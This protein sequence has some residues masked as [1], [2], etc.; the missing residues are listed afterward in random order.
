[1]TTLPFSNAILASLSSDLLNKVSTGLVR[2]RLVAGQS[3]C[4]ARYPVSTI[5][6]MEHG[7]ASVISADDS[8]GAGVEIALVGREGFVSPT[9]AL[10]P[11]AKSFNSIVAR[12]DGVAYKMEFGVFWRLLKDEPNFR[13]GIFKA[14]EVFCAEVQ[15]ISACNM[16]HPLPQRTARWL[17]LARSRLAQNH[18]NGSQE[19]LAGRLGV[20][21]PSLTHVL[22]DFEARGYIIQSRGRVQIVDRKGLEAAACGCYGRLQAFSE[23]VTDSHT[24]VSAL[25]E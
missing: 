8:S 17:L 21:R 7:V 25:R 18:I 6:F 23:L 12:F 22:G 24:S 20:A 5:Y 1:M 2:V 10:G 3:L 14:A 11:R 19:E 15:L 9:A 13:S 4:E 16:R